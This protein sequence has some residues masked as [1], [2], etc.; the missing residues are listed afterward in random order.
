MLNAEGWGQTLTDGEDVSKKSTRRSGKIEPVHGSIN[1]F[2]EFIVFLLDSVAVCD[3][4]TGLGREPGKSTRALSTTTVTH[5][6]VA[7]ASPLH[8][9]RERRGI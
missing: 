3:P 1:D 7:C 6:E 9:S 2:Y 8:M 5:S 4:Q